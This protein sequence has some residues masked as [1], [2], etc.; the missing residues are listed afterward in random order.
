[1]TDEQ[2]QLLCNWI[3]ENGDHKISWLEKE[4]VKL[5]LNKAKTVNDLL[6]M[7]VNALPKNI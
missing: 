5:A 6:E 1:M 7:A 4:A 2:L 3:R